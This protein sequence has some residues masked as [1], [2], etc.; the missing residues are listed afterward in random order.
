MHTLRNYLTHLAYRCYVNFYLKC[1]VKLPRCLKTIV[2][3]LRN[4]YFTSDQLPG[5]VTS[6]RDIINFINQIASFV[7]RDNSVFL[8]QSTIMNYL[9]TEFYNGG[10]ERYMLDLAKLLLEQGY[11]VYCVQYALDRPW[12]RNYYGLTIIGLPS[13]AKPILFRW[14]VSRLTQGIALVISSPFNLVTKENAKKII[15][16]SHGIFWDHPTLNEQATNILQSIN[17]LDR[18]VTVDTATLNVIRSQ[19]IK[20]VN[21]VVFIPNY[22]DRKKF[23]PAKYISKNE[24]LVIL[25][26]RRLY[27]PRGFWLVRALIPRLLHEF[28]DISFLFCGKA[29]NTEMKAIKVL[30]QRYGDKVKHLVCS[31][32]AMGAVYRQADIVLIPTLH[33]EGTSMSLIEAMASKKAIITTYVGGLTDLISDRF[34]GLMVYPGNNEELYQAIKAFIINKDLRDEMAKNAYEKSLAFDISLWKEKWLRVLGPLLNERK[35]TLN[36]ISRRIAEL[37]LVHMHTLGIT[38]DVMVQRPQQLFKALSL[39]GAKC[40]FLEDKP[41]D[42]QHMVNKNLIISGR[43]AHVD[44]S[45]MIV[46]TYFASNYAHIKNNKPQWLIYDVLDTPAIHSSTKYLENHDSM[47]VAADMILTS[48]QLLYQQYCHEFPEK[49]IK[50]IPNAATPSDWISGNACKPIDFPRYANKTIGYYGALAEWFDFSLL[51]KLCLDFPTCQLLLIGPCRENYSEYKQLS[52]LLEKHSNL[53][54]LGLKKYAELANYAH[55]FDVGIIPHV[56]QHKVT[57]A[58]SQ[59]KLYEYMNVGMPIVSS[60][61][62]ECRQYQSAQIA[63]NHDEFLALVRRSLNLPK[64]DTYFKIMKKEAK[65]NTWQVRA[66]CLIEAIYEHFSIE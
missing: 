65:E 31:P 19:Q 55:Y 62:P 2:K 34:N 24:R 33:S 61:I 66:N 45:G 5:D 54:Y 17:P 27:T 50:Y 14:C 1:Y 57:Q 47:L 35:T 43:E 60:D 7:D 8:V 52:S 25:Y 51:D 15:G 16:I 36:P 12:I 3:K 23:F 30:I 44:F 13:I 20:N 26:P 9:G 42:Q 32:D 58:S 4:R 63:K 39:L 22:V 37:S 53:F 6:R 21:K 48:S 28:D 49:I 10:A 41:G 64:E 46:Y 11:T 59:V 18:L 29:E 40:F 56:D 38:F